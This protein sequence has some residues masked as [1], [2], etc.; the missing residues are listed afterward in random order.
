MERLAFC[1]ALTAERDRATIKLKNAWAS[2]RVTNAPGTRACVKNNGIDLCCE[3][4]VSVNERYNA[5]TFTFPVG[6]GPG[7]A[8]PGNETNGYGV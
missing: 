1:A 4:M 3:V 2:C 5:M 8:K 6:F 7:F